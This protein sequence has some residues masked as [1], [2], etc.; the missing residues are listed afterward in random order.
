MHA[1]PELM[2]QAMPLVR[3]L[4]C[5]DQKTPGSVPIAEFAMLTDAD[6]V[7]AAIWG[8]AQVG[9]ERVTPSV[10]SREEVLDRTMIIQRAPSEP[11]DLVD[12]AA[13]TR[14]RATLAACGSYVKWRQTPTALV[15]EFNRSDTLKRRLFEA[16][17][18]EPGLEMYVGVQKLRL[19]A[20]KF[21]GEFR[22][23]A[24]GGTLRDGV[25]VDDL[26]REE[27]R[28]KARLRAE[29]GNAARWR[30]KLR[31]YREQE[32]LKVCEVRDGSAQLQSLQASLLS[33]LDQLSEVG[34]RLGWTEEEVRVLGAGGKGASL[35]MDDA[36]LSQRQAC[37]KL[38]AA[39]LQQAQAGLSERC[40]QLQASTALLEGS[41]Q[42]ATAELRALVAWRER[43]T[44]QAEHEMHESVARIEA[45]AAEREAQGAKLA[46]ALA[47][48]RDGGLE[49]L[50]AAVEEQAPQIAETR[51]LLCD[52]LRW[53]DTALDELESMRSELLS[54]SLLP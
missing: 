53:R 29:E 45:A 27:G 44:R 23:E 2:R 39:A 16:Q 54:Q 26:V 19:A 1:L 21:F 18:S 6:G 13:H 15:I 37:L 49:R 52:T 17:E 31:K 22:Q 36:E 25:T 5:A 51:S 34:R 33:S 48:M 3:R 41:V 46:R 24:G 7:V 38:E 10:G 11:L 14:L 42:A 50:A 47:T 20:T 30:R 9:Q 28:A 4:L 35:M 12:L 8:L 43:R 32:A 40:I